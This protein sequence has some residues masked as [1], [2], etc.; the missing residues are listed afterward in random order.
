[1]YILVTNKWKHVKCTVVVGYSSLNKYYP[2]HDP[3]N[4]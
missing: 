1:M 4:V 2:V 3:G